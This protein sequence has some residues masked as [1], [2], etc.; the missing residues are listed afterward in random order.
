MLDHTGRP[1]DAPC[2]SST[3]SRHCKGQVDT[4]PPTVTVNSGPLGSFSETSASFTFSANEPEV[5]FECRLEGPGSTRGSASSCMSP[6]AYSSLTAGSYTFIVRA[7]DAAGNTGGDATRAFTVVP[8]SPTATSSAT[9]TT[10]PTAI[11]SVAATPTQGSLPLDT[12]FIGPSYYSKWT[13]GPPASMDYFPIFAYHMNLGQ[14]SELPARLKAAG[15]NGI[16]MAYDESDQLNLDIARQNGFTIL[17][18]QDG[19]KVETF[20][21][22]PT[23]VTAYA[24]ADEPN[25]DGSQYAAIGDPTLDAGGNRYAQDAAAMKS[26]DPTRPVIGNFTKDVMSYAYPPSGWTSTQFQAHNSRMLKALDISSADVYGWTDN[27]EWSQ[28]NPASS[29]NFGAWVYGEQI[30]RLRSYNPNAPA[31]GFVECCASG[32]SPPSNTMMPGMIESAVW[33]MIVKG[34][35]GFTYW[36]RDF[37]HTDDQHYTGATYTGEYS[38]FGDHQWDAQFNRASQVNAQVKSYARI[39]NSPTVSGIS[40]TGQNSVPVAALGKDNGGKLWLLAQADGSNLRPLS[41][42]TPMQGTITLPST[43]P[44]GTAFDVV[45]ES[46][47]VTVNANHQIVDTFGTTTETPTYSQRALTYGYQEHIYTQR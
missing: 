8:P 23:A 20:R 11:A 34:A 2:K 26:A 45:G 40:A 25:Q 42:T 21:N 12:T 36:P 33:N 38:L 31:Y 47:T 46:R 16:Y 3:R 41:N 15:I 9:P 37:Y 43:I 32:D 17:L 35:R 22:N 14:W 19:R 7:T 5:T 1:T 44:V 27:W 39:L 4:Q 13:A 24:M 6:K 29:G 30:K 28:R 18:A 10:S